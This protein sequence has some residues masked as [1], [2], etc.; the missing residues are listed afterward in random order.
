MDLSIIIVNWNTKQ[1]LLDCLGSIYSDIASLT[2][3]VYVVDNASTDGSVE[4]VKQHYPQVK[5]YVNKKNEGFAR[6]NNRI[7]PY[8]TSR[9]VLLLNSDTQIIKGSIEALVDFMDNN[10]EAGISAPQYLN[11]DASKQNSFE[12]FPSLSSELLNKS[13]LKI[14]FPKKYPSKR[15]F[16][17]RPLAVD[18]VIGACM[19]VRTKAMAKVGYLDEDYFFFLEETDLCYRMWKAGYSVFH[20]PQIQIYHLQ[21]AS[22]NKVPAQAWIEYYRS[23]YLFFKKNK[24]LFSYISLRFFRPV[25]L[26]INFLLT[27]LGLILTLGKSKHLK[28]KWSIYFQLCLWHLKLCPSNMGLQTR[29]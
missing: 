5:L 9:Y 18:S 20:L 29:Q 24:S 23:I 11:E 10:P 1:L 26:C 8:I 25:K 16:F 28:Y 15:K 3:D 27:S 12:N 2:Y 22:K 21:G 4:A 13:L 6:A 17:H 19:M 7:L 14:I